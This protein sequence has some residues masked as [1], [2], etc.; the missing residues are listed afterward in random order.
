MGKL[1]PHAL[2]MREARST[3]QLKDKASTPRKAQRDALI[4][5]LENGPG[6]IPMTKALRVPA[7]V[8]QCVEAGWLEPLNRL[9]PGPPMYEITASGRAA[10]KG[11]EH[12]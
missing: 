2:I 6:T 7:P 9:R 3:G 4:Y 12:D 1:T 10:L 11:G 8:Q 5:I